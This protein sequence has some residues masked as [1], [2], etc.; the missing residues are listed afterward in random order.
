MVVN[1]PSCA[2]PV[3]SHGVII[4]G[5]H[6]IV[7]ASLLSPSQC[8]V[9]LTVITQKQIFSSENKVTHFSSCGMCNA[10]AR[11]S[12]LS[13]YFACHY[14]LSL[15]LQDLNQMHNNVTKCCGPVF[16]TLLSSGLSMTECACIY[17]GI[18]ECS[19]N[20]KKI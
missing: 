20:Q 4:P 7:L 5:L 9:R 14:Y 12:S 2:V 11:I 19:R 6:V 17:L 16:D 15:T 8:L 1:L 18:S 13:H 10:P 3:V